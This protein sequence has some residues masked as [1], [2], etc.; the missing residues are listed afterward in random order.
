[1]EDLFS[2]LKEKII[3]ITSNFLITQTAEKQI[4]KTWVGRMAVSRAER[5]WSKEPRIE[6]M[7]SVMDWLFCSDSLI[8]AAFSLKLSTPITPA[9]R[10]GTPISLQVLREVP[11][12]SA[13]NRWRVWRLV[14]HYWSILALTGCWWRCGL[15]KYGFS[16]YKSVF[17]VFLL[18]QLENQVWVTGFYM[19]PSNVK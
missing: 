1:M 10:T 19:C 12:K 18:P 9:V 15:Y 7:L 8:F 2:E 16:T 4:K 13:G 5:R 14:D 11:K 3:Q 6:T 17:M